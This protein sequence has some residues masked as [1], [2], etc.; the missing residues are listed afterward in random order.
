LIRERYVHIFKIN[1]DNK[2]IIIIKSSVV[3][4]S[5]TFNNDLL[6]SNYCCLYTNINSHLKEWKDLRVDSKKDQPQDQD[7]R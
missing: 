7:Q 1:F 5:N 3:V 4:V 6:I 2:K